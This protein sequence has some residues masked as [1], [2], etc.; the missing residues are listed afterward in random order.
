M[1]GPWP[2]QKTQENSSARHQGTR[3]PSLYSV[4]VRRINGRLR[5]LWILHLS[6]LHYARYL[7]PLRIGSSKVSYQKVPWLRHHIHFFK[8]ALCNHLWAEPFVSDLLLRSKFSVSQKKAGARGRLKHLPFSEIVVF[9]IPLQ[10]RVGHSPATVFIRPLRKAGSTISGSSQ[11][12]SPA[13]HSSQP[14]IMATT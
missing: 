10:Q 13:G 1:A 4:I 8:T 6:Q 12:S 3:R 5:H 2:F 7:N 11:L 14:V 9:I